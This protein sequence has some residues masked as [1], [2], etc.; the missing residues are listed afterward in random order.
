[1]NPFLWLVRVESVSRFLGPD[2]ILVVVFLYFQRNLSVQMLVLP[3]MQP[4]S[5]VALQCLSR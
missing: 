4:P 3:A 2:F 1:M 5:V